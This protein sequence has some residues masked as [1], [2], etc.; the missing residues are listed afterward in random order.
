M[1]TS[2]ANGAPRARALKMWSSRAKPPARAMSTTGRPEAATMAAY[3]RALAW[4]RIEGTPQ[5]SIMFQGLMP[6][7]PPAPSM[8]SR[9]RPASEA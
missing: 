9:S 1:Q 8:V 3:S 5:L 2:L 4:S 7:P 6:V